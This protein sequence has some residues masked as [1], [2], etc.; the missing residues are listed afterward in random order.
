MAKNR[1]R[2][3]S[4]TIRS[5]RLFDHKHKPKRVYYIEGKENDQG[6]FLKMTE[7]CAGSR[8]TLVV[9]DYLVSEFQR[10]IDKV[11]GGEDGS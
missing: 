3:V 7:A 2:I 6:P 5:F 8:N 9:P 11:K 1:G 4:K 10:A